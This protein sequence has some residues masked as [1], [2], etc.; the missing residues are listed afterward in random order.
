MRKAETVIHKLH[1]MML[2]KA[3]EMVKEGIADTLTHMRFPPQHWRYI[4]TNNPLER[5]IREI[6]RRT[7]VVGNFPDGDSALLLVA[8]R[9]RHVVGSTWGTIKY[10]NTALLQAEEETTE[11]S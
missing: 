9:F 6:G 5:I 7:R 2:G 1:S 4:K 10:L 3:A 8:A 11:A